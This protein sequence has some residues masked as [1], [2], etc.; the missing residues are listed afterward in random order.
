M[1]VHLFAEINAGFFVEL[2]DQQSEGDHGGNAILIRISMTQNEEM[3]TD[4]QGGDDAVD[5]S[6]FNSGAIDV[7]FHSECD[8]HQYNT[9]SCGRRKKI[10]AHHAH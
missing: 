1:L 7:C 5:D 3:I 6:I 4:R 2:L 9:I 10:A 8:V